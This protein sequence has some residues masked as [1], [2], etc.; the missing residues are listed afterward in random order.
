[1]FPWIATQPFDCMRTNIIQTST[2]T[3]TT[4][5]IEAFRL[6][7]KTRGF[8]GFYTG[9]SM[10]MLRSVLVNC[11]VMP[12]IEIS[13]K[14]FDFYADDRPKEDMITSINRNI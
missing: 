11:C 9:L 4:R 10:T 1:L 5:Q 12:T 13:H 14:F 8:R 6:I 2:N 3:R 7:Y